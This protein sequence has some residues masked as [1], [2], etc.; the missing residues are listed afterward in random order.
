M[1]VMDQ[2]SLQVGHLL[3]F[4]TQ[5]LK[6]MARGPQAH[7]EIGHAIIYMSTQEPI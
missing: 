6:V 5:R 7:R 2:R 4:I 1:V 3:H